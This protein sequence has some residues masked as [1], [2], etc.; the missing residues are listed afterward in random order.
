[1]GEGGG[2][3]SFW[4]LSKTSWPPQLLLRPPLQRD[5]QNVRE[6][7][8][9]YCNWHLPVIDIH[10]YLGVSTLANAAAEAATEARGC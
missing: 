5:L 1:M 8:R 2:G 9:S 7:E 4:K 6:C 3:A 10:G